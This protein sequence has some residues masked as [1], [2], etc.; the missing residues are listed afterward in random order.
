MISLS[1]ALWRA[2]AKADPTRL[3]IASLRDV[4]NDPLAAKLKWRLKKAGLSPEATE[5]IKVVYSS[6][7][8]RMKLL[9]LSTEQA[10][11]PDEFGAM[12]NFR[13]RVIPVLGTIPAI[14]GMAMASFAATE[15]AGLPIVPQPVPEVSRNVVKKLL[16]RA[17]K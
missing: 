17:K 8:P 12:P 6:E 14:F 13:V 3:H 4:C 10:E 7:K 15:L 1:S 2:G 5:S 11:N 9:P 16:K